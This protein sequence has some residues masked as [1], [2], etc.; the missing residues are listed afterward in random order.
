MWGAALRSSQ[1]QRLDQQT[2]S[3]VLATLAHRVTKASPASRDDLARRSAATP[4]PEGFSSSGDRRYRHTDGMPT[5][6]YWTITSS[7]SP[8]LSASRARL[9]SETFGETQRGGYEAWIAG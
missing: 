3:L 8:A 6:C 2:L 1:S 7:G 9:L 4:G 5:W